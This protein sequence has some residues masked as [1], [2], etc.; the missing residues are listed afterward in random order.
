MDAQRSTI[1]KE[2]IENGSVHQRLKQQKENKR[3]MGVFTFLSN[4]P[5]KQTTH[6][7]LYLEGRL[8]TGCFL[9][10]A[11]FLKLSITTH[12][13]SQAPNHSDFHNQQL[14]TE[15]FYLPEVITAKADRAWRRSFIIAPKGEML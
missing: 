12:S 11:T 13:W 4:I 8:S 6:R 10:G 7:L 5:P 9:V 1:G 15:P 2:E 14:H 3:K